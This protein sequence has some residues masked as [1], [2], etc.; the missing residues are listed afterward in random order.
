MA[1]TPDKALREKAVFAAFIF[2][3]ILLP[4]ALFIALKSGSLT[5]LAEVIRGI[6]LV[7]VAVLSW[8]TLRRI[9]RQQLGGYDFGLGKMEQVLSFLVALAL[10]ASIAFV[11][12][13]SLTQQA[14]IPHEIAAWKFLAVGM[15]FMNF[16]ANAA[17][18]P[19]LYKAL[20]TGKSV[21]VLTQ[22]RTKVAKSI[23]SAISTVCVA[24]NQLSSD[25]GLSLW[26]DRAGIF[27]VTLVTL[28]AAYELMK[29][30]IPD[31]LDRTLPEDHQVK[32]NQV[33]ARHYHDFESLSWCRSRQ[34]GSDI[35][36][37]VGLGFGPAMPFGRV[38][39][40]AK[41]VMKDIEDSVPGSRAIVTP[42]LPD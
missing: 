6:F 38:A 1:I 17:P 19:P 36:V 14:A 15:T 31:I 25:P 37:H 23:G 39:E 4:L 32:I 29:S 8:F 11:W 40:I 22:F 16:F 3:V 7:S 35:E 26:A 34:S 18:L 20:K 21:L 2:D 33:L 30:S 41:A 42:V 12:Y 5:M 10:C 13:K 24:I 27:I 28:H 9:H